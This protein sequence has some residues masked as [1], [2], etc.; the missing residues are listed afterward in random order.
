MLCAI[1]AIP[2][3]LFHLHFFYDSALAASVIRPALRLGSSCSALYQAHNVTLQ[4]NFTLTALPPS[5]CLLELPSVPSTLIRLHTYG[6]SLGPFSSNAAPI[7][8]AIEEASTHSTSDHIKW[9]SHTYTAKDVPV[10]LWVE[11][12]WGPSWFG[13]SMTWGQWGAAAQA[14]LEFGKEWE[15]VEMGFEV[16]DA[17][18]RGDVAFGWLRGV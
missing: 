10:Q 14:I 3:L 9:S 12:N 7:L 11:R 6:S 1:N 15:F 17:G 13:E 8:R 5:P 18:D 16:V 4:P 2:V